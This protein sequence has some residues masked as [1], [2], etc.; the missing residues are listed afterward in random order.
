MIQIFLHPYELKLANNSSVR[1]GYLLKV[2]DGE[3]FSGYSDVFPWVE[4]GDPT[5]EQI[6]NEFNQKSS[7]ELV[8]RSFELA[9]KDLEA[10]KESRSLIH[11]SSLKNHYSL[12]TI[13]SKAIDQVEKALSDGFERIKIKIGREEENEKDFISYL[14][15]NIHNKDFLRFDFNTNGNSN[16]ISF[17]EQFS[18]QIEFI[19]DPFRDPANWSYQ[20]L[21]FAF[22]HPGFSE[23]QVKTP[24]RI[25]K[26]EKQSGDYPIEEKLVFTSYLGHP[27]GQAHAFAEAQSWGEQKYEYGLMT[28]FQYE[29]SD[30]SERFSVQGP[31]L[32]MK[33]KEGIGFSDIL[34]NLDWVSL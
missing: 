10:R 34:S 14:C 5:Y 8:N 33:V 18:D 13:N 3:G 1:R 6:P 17:L 4:F 32:S 29:P 31:N 26:P 19:E 16:Y 12:G 27:V 21:E 23:D 30:F 24:W 9:H 28:Q 22:D 11:E 20:K 2:Q 25:I 7:F 15:K